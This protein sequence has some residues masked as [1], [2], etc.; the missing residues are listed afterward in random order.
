MD[1]LSVA[2]GL[3]AAS[4]GIDIRGDSK[5]SGVPAKREEEGSQGKEATGEAAFQSIVRI[6]DENKIDYNVTTHRP[7]K[8]S[9]ESADVRGVTLASGA[10]AMLMKG[11]KVRPFV[12]H[13]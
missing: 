6:L 13:N 11:A 8:T 12:P 3:T 4:W 7:T 9:Q 5:P 10:K 2:W 1:E